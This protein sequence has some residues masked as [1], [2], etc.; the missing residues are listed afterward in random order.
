[1]NDSRSYVRE[2][3]NCF[4]NFRQLSVVDAGVEFPP[5]VPFQG[6]LSRDET[7]ADAYRMELDSD[8]VG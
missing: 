4:E 3:V 1:M 8:S 7:H 2:N 5:A 6:E